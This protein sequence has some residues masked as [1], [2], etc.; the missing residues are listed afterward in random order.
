MIVILEVIFVKIYKQYKSEVK[1]VQTKDILFHYLI[2]IQALF[3]YSM[4]PIVESSLIASPRLILS[5]VFS[6]LF[7]FSKSFC[8]YFYARS[9]IVS[10]HSNHSFLGI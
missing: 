4:T 1:Y 10:L 9:L 2:L 3:S 8:Y 7:T 6:Q 5:L